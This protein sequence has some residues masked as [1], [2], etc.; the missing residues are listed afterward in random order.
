MKYVVYPIKVGQLIL[1]VTGGSSANEQQILKGVN[2]SL[3]CGEV[4]ATL[5]PSGA[6]TTCLMKCLVGRRT[7]GVT[8]QIK[9]SKFFRLKFSSIPQ[10]DHLF[11][12]LTV[13]EATTF[14]SK[15]KNAIIETKSEPNQSS[16][17]LT[18]SETPS[19]EVFH[20]NLV[21]GILKDLRLLVC[22]DTRTSSLSG[23]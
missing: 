23:G 20:T 5:G 22:I 12:V 4:T 3:K 17:D 11:K 13:C 2:G 14:S 9:V 15:L 10:R 18:E 7:A 16:A 6:G 21:H 19:I 8:G 1:R